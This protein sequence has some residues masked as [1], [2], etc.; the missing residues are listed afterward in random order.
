MSRYD[1]PVDHIIDEAAI[2]RSLEAARTPDEARLDDLLAKALELKGLS[3]DEVAELMQVEDLLQRERM[4]T[5]A[6]EIKRRIYGD[7]I[8]LFAPLYVSNECLGNCLYCGFRSDNTMLQRRTLSPAEVAGE[9]RWL[10]DH[11]YKRLLLVFGDHPH[12]AVD[13]M[14][15]AVRAVYSVK[16]DSGEIRRVNI[17]GAPLSAE[18]F[19]RLKPAGIGTYQVFQ[20]TYHR[21]TYER[22]HPTGPKRHYAWRLSVW[23]RC[24]PSGID[25]MGI[26]V[27]YGLHDWR[28]DTLAML[29]HAA[30][31]DRTFGVG[32]HTISVPRLEPAYNTPL[33]TNP[34]AE[35]TDD[36]FKRI[37]AIARLAVPYT[38][39]IMSTRETA[40]MRTEC[41][42]LGVSQI[43]AGSSTSPG[44]Y[45][46][47]NPDDEDARQFEL[48]DH[49]PLDEVMGDLCKLGYLPSFCTACY[50]SGRTGREF[51][52][53]AKPGT[54]AAFCLPNALIT[55]KEYLLDYAE[56]ETRIAGEAVIVSQLAK[57]ES[58]PLREEV[59]RRLERLEQAERDLYF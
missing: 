52:A 34:P 17:N 28:W 9:V 35:V 26:G 53:M 42:R 24:F 20:E 49:R 19:C 3:R 44:G 50:R 40:Q 33:A 30:Y 32:P 45:T 54:I 5:A 48:G 51:M 16:H 23:D 29:D 4:F 36:D 2:S 39:I 7:R 47:Q 15:E 25:D 38:G 46:E 12:N 59:T 37:V 22:M 56:P 11:G 27:L 18:D 41:L 57:V 13:A 21:A 1:I 55:F 31:M 43:S 10:I 58:Q 14:I 6:A 8:V